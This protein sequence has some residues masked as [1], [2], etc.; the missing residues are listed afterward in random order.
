[1]AKGLTP[2]EEEIA[3]LFASGFLATEIAEAL[4]VS[5][6]YIHRVL[7]RVGIKYGTL[8]RSA[9]FNQLTGGV[10]CWSN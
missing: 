7:R 3:T 9:L 6:G 5:I 10:T 8:S 2:K 4:G 1:M